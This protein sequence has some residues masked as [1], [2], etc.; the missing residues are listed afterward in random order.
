MSKDDDK[1]NAAVGRRILWK[2]WSRDAFK[3]ARDSNK[4]VLLDLSAEWCHWCH[5]MDN[6]TYS[7]SRVIK[8]VNE[9][10]IPIRV[11]I[12]KRPDI[13]ER[14][15]RG[16]FPTTAFLS[17]QGEP[18]W[19]STYIPPDDMVGVLDA[20]LSAKDKGEVKAALDQRQTQHLNPSKSREDS[21][22]VDAEFV[23]AIFEDIF[24]TYDPEW[25]GFGMEPKFP[26]PSAIDLLIERYASSRD[27][28]LAEAVRSTLDHMT[29]GLYD[30]VEGG[31]FRY[32]VSRDWKVPHYEKMLETNVGFVRNLTRAYVVLGDKRYE[33]TALGVADYVLDTLRDEESGGF[34]SSQDAD[35]EYYVLDAA[36]RD[37]RQRP[38]VIKE[39][40]SGLNCRAVSA[41]IEAGTIL[42]RK[43]WTQA[44][45]Q[46]LDFTITRQWN[47]NSGLV[48]HRESEE[49]YLFDD[50]VDF[51]E[52]LLSAA[53]TQSDLELA[54]TLDLAAGL[55]R[56]V[57]AAFAHSEGGFGDVTRNPDAV[58]RLAEPERSISANSRWARLASLVGIATADLEL[59]D[60]SWS[61]LKSF[62]R[63]T[64]QMNGIFAADYVQAWD[65][66]RLGPLSVEL[67][68]LDGDGFVEE[69]LWRSAK[70]A[71]NPGT[72]VLKARKTM[73]E[74]KA[75]RPFAVVCSRGGCS[76]EIFEPG[77]LASKLKP[78]PRSQI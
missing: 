36:G 73:L 29:V 69:P 65:S 25:G 71:M 4:L 30:E 21:E 62:S 49:L 14:Y 54:Q 70:V 6:T 26:H 63:R 52:A 42:D 17:D 39:V 41:L 35:E 8:M 5:V 51:L 16:G 75:P 3:E 48:R 76:K 43:E 7:D 22:T 37:Q 61:V 59:M 78:D 66:L 20:M 38:K 33:D 9:R 50:Q 55:V 2:D 67:H 72:I 58:G 68:G 19:G 24:I 56:G 31:V 12:D 10:F 13:S 28:E 57:H 74:M 60:M 53:E 46:A 18:L 34:Y 1:N 11:D 27:Q 47:V 23:D 77:E 40:F 32:S 15:N 64:V 44:A 45:K